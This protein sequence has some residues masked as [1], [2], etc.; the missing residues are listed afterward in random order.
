MV[1]QRKVRALDP[2][3]VAS[4]T[5]RGKT[6]RIWDAVPGVKNVATGVPGT[7]VQADA[8]GIHVLAGDGVLILRR[9]QAEGGKILAAGDFL[10]GHRLAAGDRLGNETH[11]SPAR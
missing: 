4:T 11:D 9:L 8:S 2:W 1:L 3:P 5:W 7:V 10:N 6:L